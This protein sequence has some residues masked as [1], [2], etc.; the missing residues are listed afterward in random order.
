[1]KGAI[2]ADFSGGNGSDSVDQFTGV[3]GGGWAGAWQ[4]NTAGTSGGTSFSSSVLGS[5]PLNSGGDY[6]STVLIGGSGT[7]KGGVQR[8]YETSGSV[9]LSAVH[10]LSFDFRIDSDLSTFTSTTDYLQAFDRPASSDFGSNGT[11]L[12]RAAGASVNGINALNW[13]FYDGG[14]DGA[15]FNTANF[16]DSG[17]ALASGTVYHFEVFID[18]AA[19]EYSVSINGG[20]ISAPLGFRTGDAGNLGNL[21][22]GGQVSSAGEEM[23]FSLDSVAV[24]PEPSA[25]ALLLVAGCGIGLRRRRG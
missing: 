3:A 9:D 6:L 19:L 23:A 18:P 5:S 24:V 11:W 2:T 8:A 4:S 21:N 10:Q 14:Q 25:T 22:F 12:I 17:V 20:P 16:V 7:S 15:G 13:M 1:M